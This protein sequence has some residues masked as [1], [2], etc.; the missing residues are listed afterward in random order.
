MFGTHWI[1]AMAV[2]LLLAEDDLL[3]EAQIFPPIE[4]VPLGS[5]ATFFCK[6]NSSVYTSAHLY[7]TLNPNITAGVQDGCLNE[8]VRFITIQNISAESVKIICKISASDSYQDH[9]LDSISITTGNPPETPHNISCIYFH[10]RNLTCAWIT[11]KNTRLATTFTLSRISSLNKSVLCSTTN[12]SCTS[13]YIGDGELL[14]GEY[15]VQ[16]EAENKLG[17][18]ACP[19][20]LINTHRLVKMDPP[21]SLFLKPSCTENSLFWLEMSWRRSILAPDDLN[22]NCALRYKQ[23]QSVQWSYH[24]LYMQKEAQMCYNLTGLEAFTDY[25]VSMRCIGNDGQIFWSE[26]SE[27][28]TIRT[29]EKAPSHSVELWRVITFS[30]N[31]RLVHLMWKEKSYIKPSGI[32]QGF[33]VQWHPEDESFALQNKTTRHNEMVLSLPNKAYILSVIYYNSAG[34]SPSAKLRI[35][36]I[37]EKTQNLIHSAQ[38]FIMNE[39]VTVIWNITD[40]RIMTYM[41]EWCIDSILNPCNNI[42]FQQV[43]NSSEWTGSKGIF[44]PYTHYRISVYP[45]LETKV[46]APITSYFYVKEAAPLH[47][48]NIT[49]VNLKETEATIKWNPIRQDDANGFL[50]SF[51]AVYNSNDEHESIT[52]SSDVYEY[53]LKS[54]KPKTVYTAYVIASTRAG[55]TSGHHVHFTTHKHNGEEFGLVIGI[56]GA[57]VVLV[58]VFGIAYTRKK[59]MIKHLL[60]PDVPD[61]AHS[62]IIEWSLD[63]VRAALLVDPEQTDGVF[64]EENLHVLHSVYINEKALS[65]DEEDRKRLSADTARS[66]DSWTAP[67]DSSPVHYAITEIRH[68]LLESMPLLQSMSGS[69]ASSCSSLLSSL[70]DTNSEIQQAH[71]LELEQ[72]S[73]DILAEVNPYLK[74]SI[75]TREVI[76]SV[77]S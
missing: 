10:K 17:K 18:V 8:T 6:V 58:V 49:V 27:D 74:N 77:N 75:N 34:S 20:I 66:A 68:E 16:V 11:R 41:V 65:T 4:Y 55:N 43:E 30:N 67:E 61:P 15:E 47:G 69:M 26:W 51:S 39:T 1:L 52:V 56:I 50:T 62:S 9:T 2:K 42:S 59:E 76:H 25:T 64:H 44:E 45:I 48:P 3:W 53:T 14:V 63:W 36:A 72:L 13:F 35:P 54:L 22:V 19:V 57:L 38:L 5:S 24:N 70:G 33:V 73:G 32:T 46:E 71:V 28:I 31:T 23:L 37:K 60:W 7:W 29:L 40:M 21:N 12:N